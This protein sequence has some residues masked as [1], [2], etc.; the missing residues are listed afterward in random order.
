LRPGQR[1]PL[2]RSCPRLTLQ[3]RGGADVGRRRPMS[4]TAAQW[5]RVPTAISPLRT[6]WRHRARSR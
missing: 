2:C 1:V 3:I 6:I 4:A 5:Q